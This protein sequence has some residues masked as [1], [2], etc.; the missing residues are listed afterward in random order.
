MPR[1]SLAW[2]EGCPT[3]EVGKMSVIRTH[4]LQ[5]LECLGDIMLEL[6]SLYIRDLFT[7]S[8]LTTLNLDLLAPVGYVRHL[9][10]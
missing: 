6:Y 2:R 4:G 5:Y 9:T 10:P 8:I 3:E 7:T 1:T